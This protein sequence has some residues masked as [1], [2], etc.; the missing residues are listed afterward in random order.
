MLYVVDYENLFERLL[1]TFRVRLTMEHKTTGRAPPFANTFNN[2]AP[3]IGVYFKLE[4]IE[5]IDDWK[6]IFFFYTCFVN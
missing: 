2:M 6:F 1:D 3:T 5:N 4:L